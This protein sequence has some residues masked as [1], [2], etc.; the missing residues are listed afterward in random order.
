[1][2][3]CRAAKCVFVVAL[4]G[5][6]T[7]CTA[8][9]IAV[10]QATPKARAG[11]LAKGPY[12]QNL[13]PTQVVIC[14]EPATDFDGRIVVEKVA[15][16]ASKIV[17]FK[18]Q[19]GKIAEV[20]V[21]GLRPSTKYEYTVE[22]VGHRTAATLYTGSFTTAP[23][24]GHLPVEFVVWGDSRSRAA[25]CKRIAE[26][27]L[28]TGVA[29]CVHTGDLVAAGREL[30]YWQTDLFE[31]ARDLLAR[32]SIFPVVGNHELGGRGKIDGYTIFRNFFS[33]PGNEVWYSFDYGGVHFCIL[34]SNNY[35]N[36]KQ[37]DWA[38]KDLTASK[39][40]W[41]VV[42]FH[43]PLYC[44]GSHDSHVR[45]RRKYAALFAEA[46]VDLIVTGHDHNYQRTKPIRQVF[47]PNGDKP[48]WHIVTGGGGAP[49]Y[50]V[51]KQRIWLETG[52]SKNHFVLVRADTEKMSLKV[53]DV[54]G[55]VIDR[56]E[57]VK[58]LPRSRTVA[59]EQIELERNIRDSKPLNE[60]GQPACF[61]VE[62]GATQVSR[63]YVFSN[64]WPVRTS[65]TI[66]NLENGTYRLRAEP[67][68]ITL[69]EGKPDKPSTAKVK[70][71]LEVLDLKR[72]SVR[73][74]PQMTVRYEA[75]KIGSGEV[76]DLVLP[77]TVAQHIKAVRTAK[78]V[79]I[80]GKLNEPVWDKAA[81]VATATE[82]DRLRPAPRSLTTEV[83]AA[84]DAQTLYL[85]ITCWLPKGQ[86]PTAAK[87]ITAGDHLLLWFASSP[88]ET[89]TVLISPD[90]RTRTRAGLP[91]RIATQTGEGRWT[92]EVA[93][94]LKALGVTGNTRQ[95]RFN[96]TRKPAKRYYILVPT[97][98]SGF[99][100]DAAA[101]LILPD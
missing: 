30:R 28:K 60:K 44:A 12:L 50:K 97:F 66:P 13:Q 100:Y 57:I 93:I 22:R 24:P 47:A 21:S 68:R 83:L 61:V 101:R 96:L 81:P 77:V 56:F 67:S 55:K 18:A 91:V 27:I 2:K 74:L 40:R 82:R 31:P 63:F 19:A 1:M 41:K 90:G 17:P 5:M 79:A 62:E 69:P 3:S 42:A 80:D 11:L 23:P 75:E 15:G 32:C 54:A 37:Y 46:G 43:H 26:R 94:P 45:M 99:D 16:Q 84:A 86:K 9:K 88:H 25:I 48:Y 71:T 36:S 59:Y 92:A 51:R 85:G 73:N 39:A 33:L 98:R 34:D 29:I 52:A 20:L 4:V 89:L 70:V 95:L 78:P 49:L 8:A 6:T 14:M 10:T 65:I 58:N 38:R 64:P 87:R 76:R 7:V 53:I 72:V 35:N